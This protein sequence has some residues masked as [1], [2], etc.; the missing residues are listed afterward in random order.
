MS[1]YA[2]YPTPHERWQMTASPLDLA[3]DAFDREEAGAT[4]RDGARAGCPICQ[5][6]V[7]DAEDETCAAW[8][9]LFDDPAC[10]TIADTLP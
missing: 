3:L 9:F 8:Q 5:R 4:E 2:E 10:L 7:R 6:G 1:C